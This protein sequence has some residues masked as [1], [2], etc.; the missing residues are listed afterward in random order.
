ME[1]KIK[2]YGDKSNFQSKQIPKQ[3]A[4]YKCLSLIMF[5]SLI[6]VNKTY[7]PQTQM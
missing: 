5:D 2:S 1:T 4:S 3:N 6:R 7:Y